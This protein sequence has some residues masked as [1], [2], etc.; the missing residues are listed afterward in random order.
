MALIIIEA[1]SLQGSYERIF[2]KICH[3]LSP[4]IR[5][6]FRDE[7]KDE[8]DL[9]LKFPP[10]KELER[11]TTAI[12]KKMWEGNHLLEYFKAVAGTISLS[13]LERLLK[14]YRFTKFKD[15]KNT[16]ADG[17]GEDRSKRVFYVLATAQ[18]I[19]VLKCFI[20]FLE[21][22]LEENRPLRYFYV[23]KGSFD[24]Y[25]KAACNILKTRNN[26]PKRLDLTLELL[27][28]D[29]LKLEKFINNTK[30]FLINHPEKSISQAD[31]E[32]EE[33]SNN[34]QDNNPSN[35]PSV[36]ASLLKP[37]QPILNDTT[38]EPDLNLESLEGDQLTLEKYRN[39]ANEYLEK[40]PEKNLP[41][42]DFEDKQD[43]DDTR[44]NNHP[45]IKTSSSVSS[46][47]SIQPQLTVPKARENNE[48]YYA[49]T[50]L[51]VIGRDK[52]K[53]RLGE[54]LHSDLNVAWF[55][56][57]GGA[58]QGKSR[59]AFDLMRD[60]LEKWGWRAGFLKEDDIEF[61]KDHWKDWQPD[62]PHLLIFDYVIG[63]EHDIKPILQTLI[64]N[65]NKYHYK[66][67]ILLIERQRWD[68]GSLIKK[69]DQKENDE[70]RLSAH[71]GDK[72]QWLLN[73][74]EKDDFEAESLRPYR[75]EDGVEELKKTEW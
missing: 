27:E 25:I 7:I 54:F 19:S 21:F 57:A 65:Q 44:Y 33:N 32:D 23:D 73:L 4:K 36:S 71:I 53:V 6:I 43:S 20:Q 9:K 28:G 58:G 47:Q 63:R 46:F 74:C 66:I 72:A 62:K 31:F 26:K 30:E 15:F 48:N 60:A 10:E 29:R 35:N 64:S 24:R 14:Q 2:N 51:Q 61:F 39:G 41:Q 50:V 18:Q 55:Q 34:I 12:L 69:Q 1:L 70:L 56:L 67:R 17:F 38:Y 68:R 59:L 42:A 37:I 40:N 75:F 5:G 8:I 22:C 11:A 49:D 52:Q 3:Q 45:P 16:F 13:D